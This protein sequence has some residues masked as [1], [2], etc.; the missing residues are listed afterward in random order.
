MPYASKA[1]WMPNKLKGLFISN[2]SLSLKSGGWSGMNVN[3]FEQLTNHFDCDYG[4]PI[5][6]PVSKIEQLKSKFKS[7][8]GLGRNFEFFSEN[9]L[10]KISLQF[11]KQAITDIDFIF[12]H[13]TTPWIKCKPACPYYAY[14]DATFLTYLDIYLKP[15][16]FST[17]E[18]T[19]IANQETDFLNNAKAIFFSSEWA[20]LE[21]IKRYH[22][23]GNNFHTIGLG[24]NS[25]VSTPNPKQNSTNLLFVSMDFKRKG[26]Q[27]A[28]DAFK[29][30]S[31]KFSG[32]KL[33][34]IGDKPPQPIIEASGVIYHGFIDK[35]TEKGQKRFDEIFKEAA[36][37]IHPTEKDMTPLIIVE[38]GYYGIPAIAPARFG[39]PEMI[40]DGK[41]G[42]LL[43]NNTPTEIKSRLVS[44][45]ASK[46]ELEKI[47]KAVYEYMVIN[48]TWKS[49][50]NKIANEIKAS[51]SKII[52]T[53]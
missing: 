47:Q 10:R 43:K 28:Y 17:K 40:I 48:F 5:N 15:G 8:I 30:L 22:L 1:L 36:L 37:L 4:I 50:G 34:I 49:T 14:V 26:G 44:T 20:R 6:P 25:R 19:R 24:G 41:T 46:E 18:I 45:L 2:L 39:I 35:S 11:E 21:T 7:I 38:A 13:G 23:Q 51:I 42:F 52:Q 27:I 33:H 29:Q 16:K 12:F 53:T 9:R 31:K 32:L 3:V